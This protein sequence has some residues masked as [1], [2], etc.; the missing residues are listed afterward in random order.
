MQGQEDEG[1]QKIRQG[2]DAYQASGAEMDRPYFL[3][4]LAES[5]LLSGEAEKGIAT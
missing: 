3:A 2:L 4:L 1:N 5:E